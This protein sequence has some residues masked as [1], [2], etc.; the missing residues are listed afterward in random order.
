M[1]DIS[2]PTG[3]TGSI[4]EKSKKF[5]HFFTMD[6]AVGTLVERC[7]L[8]PSKMG[9][10]WSTSALITNEEIVR[11][12]HKSYLDVGADVILTNTYQMH[13]AGCAQAGV[14][15]NEVVNT[16]VRVLCDGITPERAAATKEAK[17]WA[18]HVMNNK[19]SEFVNVFAPLFYGPR[20]DASKCPVLVGGS[21]GSYGASLGN[22]QEYRGEYEVNEDII[23]DYY[24]GRFMAFVNHVDEKEAHLKV[25]FIM[26]ETIPLLNEA[27]EIFTWLKYQKE[28][29]TLRSAPVCLSFISCLREPRPD[30]TVDDATLNE[31]WLA[32]ESNIR[33]IDGN[34]FEKAFNSLMELQLPQ[35]VGFGTNCCSPLEASVVASAFLKKKKHKVTDPSLA[36]FLYSNSGENFKEGEWHWGG[37]L[38]RGSHSPTSSPK[39]TLPFTT[40]QRLMLCC[41][42]DV[43]TA[44]FF[45]YQ[46]LLQ[47]PEA[48]DWLFDIIICG[49]CCR[50]T[51]EDIAM[52]RSLV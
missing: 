5:Q 2:C 51:P 11:Y 25:D 8:D 20:D 40:L 18:Q 14:T 16:A 37:Q 34:T 17:V 10:M 43:R 21:L 36:L 1:K 44:A 4:F 22:A 12:V 31:W 24:V 29:E 28:D 27:I 3:E 45:A 35:L 7:G 46:L 52:I 42:A 47:R 9:S 15:M 6:G 33:L 30:V 41:E 19:R 13:A 48:D 38:P 50:S 49:G 26:I 39:E 23:R 32:A